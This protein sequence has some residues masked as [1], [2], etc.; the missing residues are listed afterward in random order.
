MPGTAATPGVQSDSDQDFSQ[1]SRVQAIK[2]GAVE[3]LAK[4]FRDRSLDAIQHALEIDR[5]ARQ[6]RST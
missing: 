6:E 2:E 4:P 1:P 3:F 5:A